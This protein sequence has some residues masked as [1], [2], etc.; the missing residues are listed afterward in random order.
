MLLTDQCYKYPYAP[1]FTDQNP[2]SFEL[3]FSKKSATADIDQKLKGVKEGIKR[4][5]LQLQSFV[6]DNKQRL[7][8]LETEHN[9]LT[10]TF[11]SIMDAPYKPP[12]LKL[13]FPE[14]DFENIRFW[15][16][17]C[18]SCFK[19]CQIPDHLKMEYV[20]L[21]IKGK[22]EYWYE[23]YVSGHGESVITWEKFCVDICQRFGAE[24][25]DVMRKFNSVEQSG[26]M[27]VEKYLERFA[28]AMSAMISAFTGDVLLVLLYF[29]IEARY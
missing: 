21:N 19:L 11:H 28:E 27:D 16:R 23:C 17:R 10:S 9:Q 13:K 24:P 29:R 7:D 5:E 4:M 26:D 3:I 2:S 8:K 25:M 12:K 14:F 20:S 18:N 1:L 6:A 22:A 15:I